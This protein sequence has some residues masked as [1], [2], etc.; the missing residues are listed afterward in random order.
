[1]NNKI[2]EYFSYNSNMFFDSIDLL[3]NLNE[4]FVLEGENY[5]LEEGTDIS[6]I[7]FKLLAQLYFLK[8]KDNVNNSSIAHVCYIIAYY[9]GLFLHP[10]GGD[11]IALKYIDEAIE[12]ETD[13]KK[14]DKYRELISMIKEEI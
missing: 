4:E 6:N 13:L 12:S 11:F 7:Y 10:T 3:D 14:I 8:S 5:L 2:K 1:M 9:V